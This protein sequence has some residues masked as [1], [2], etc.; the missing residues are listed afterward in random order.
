MIPHPV[1]ALTTAEPNPLC[2]SNPH[3]FIEHAAPGNHVGGVAG[4]EERL[5]RRLHS[6][7]LCR[8]LPAIYSEH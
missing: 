8:Q 6:A 1:D 7:D 5:D 2:V 4:H 3:A